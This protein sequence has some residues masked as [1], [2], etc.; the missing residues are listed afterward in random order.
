[1]V[2]AAVQRRRRSNSL[3]AR[4]LPDVS[5]IRSLSLGEE[6]EENKSTSKEKKFFDPK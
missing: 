6:I 3:S 5:H 1:M 2:W 4:L